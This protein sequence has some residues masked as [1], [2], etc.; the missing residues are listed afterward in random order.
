MGRLVW[1]A[2]LQRYTGVPELHCSS[3]DR[4]E[5]FGK[6]K[7]GEGWIGR[8]SDGDLSLL[9]RV[10][11]RS[12]DWE[13]FGLEGGRERRSPDYVGPPGNQDVSN[14]LDRALQR[15]RKLAQVRELLTLLDRFADTPNPALSEI[16]GQL[17]GPAPLPA[18]D[19]EASQNA[20]AHHRMIGA[21]NG[22]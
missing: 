11:D 8:Q 3:T 19:S 1:E 9:A 21:W 20:V 6:A 7:F 14:A 4:E 5:R 16:P 2:T 10:R 22:A 18:Q 15:K 13:S 17:V 12:G